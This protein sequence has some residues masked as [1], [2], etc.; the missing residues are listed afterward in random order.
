[1]IVWERGHTLETVSAP[2]TTLLNN[3]YVVFDDGTVSFLSH[4]SHHLAEGVV[5]AHKYA[6]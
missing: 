1:M 4:S 3:T 6:A 5:C 2:I